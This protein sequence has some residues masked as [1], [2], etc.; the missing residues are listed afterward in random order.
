MRR[1]ESRVQAKDSESWLHEGAVQELLLD[2]EHYE[3]LVQALLRA[4]DYGVLVTDLQGK[5]VF[6]NPRFGVLFGMDAEQVVR[7]PREVVRQWAVDCVQDPDTFIALIDSAYAAPLMEFQD[8]VALKQPRESIL[9]RHSAPI[10]DNAG[11]VIGRV[12]TFL[13]VTETRRLQ[14]EVASYAR[15]LEERLE[16]QALELHA[17]HESLLEAAQMRAVGTLAVGIA[18]DLRNILTTLRLEMATAQAPC[19]ALVGGQLDRLYALTHSLLALSE[20]TPIQAGAVDL[21]EI[22]D[23]VFRLVYSQAEVDGVRLVKNAPEEV[24]PVFGNAR[25]LE[26]LVVN[27]LLNALNAVGPTGGEVVVTLTQQE[28]S[29]RLDVEDSGPGIPPEHQ[30][31]LFEPF[32]TT[33]ANRIGLGLFSA[34]R[35]VDAHQ[36]NIQITSEPGK[37]ARVSVWLPVVETASQPSLLIHTVSG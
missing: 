20:E 27:L 17:A 33:R 6:C 2:S 15:R 32:F 21:N 31:H 23:F 9:R 7:L 11:T 29:V 26:H 24:T 4:T 36:G 30:A 12:W 10:M 13:D 16:A 14:Q 18:H 34:R 22:V 28:T 35:I 5:D 25:R 8:E 37:G 19:Q 3:S 1:T